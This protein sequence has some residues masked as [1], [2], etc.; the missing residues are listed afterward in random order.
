[1]FYRNSGAVNLSPPEKR[2]TMWLSLLL[3]LIPHV[4]T[5]IETVHGDVASG[6]SKK[7]MAMDALKAAV[8]AASVADPGDQTLIDAASGLASTVIDST[9]AFYNAN[10]WPKAGVTHELPRVKKFTTRIA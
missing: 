1:M 4:I 10:G 8:G 5:G 3:S 6:A 9:V 2:K 7:Q